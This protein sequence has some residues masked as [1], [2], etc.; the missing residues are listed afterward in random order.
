[1]V[2]MMMLG[3]VVGSGVGGELVVVASVAKDV[4][5]MYYAPWDPSGKA[6]VAMIATTETFFRQNHHLLINILL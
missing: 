3:V 4:F 1:M 6:V 5:V 2:M